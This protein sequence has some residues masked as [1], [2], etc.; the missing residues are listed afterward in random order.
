MSG[1][2]ESEGIACAAASHHTTRLSPIYTE[3]HVRSM[4]PHDAAG[5]PHILRL[6]SRNVEA[7]SL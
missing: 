7:S 3:C 5:T 1:N 2:V 6:S 4:C